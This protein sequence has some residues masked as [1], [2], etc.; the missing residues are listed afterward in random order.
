MDDKAIYGVHR[1]YSQNGISH[2]SDLETAQILSAEIVGYIRSMGA[3]PMLFELMTVKEKND[4]TVIPKVVLE[5]LNVL[6]NGIAQRKWEITA[7]SGAV[8]FKGTLTNRRGK[9]HPVVPG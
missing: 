3:D 8:Y 4:V 7:R 6:N 1:F 2:D 5:K 9:A